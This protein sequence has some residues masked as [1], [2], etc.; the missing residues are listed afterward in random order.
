MKI[1]INQPEDISPK[2]L[3]EGQLLKGLK[4]GIYL[5]T[6]NQN[7]TTVDVVVINPENSYEFSGKIMEECHVDN[8][9][10][11]AGSVTLSND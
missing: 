8:F 11:F 3:Q 1:Q 10:T 4:G 2:S 9:K 5:C 7:G 6:S